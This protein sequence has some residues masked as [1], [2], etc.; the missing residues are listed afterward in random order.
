MQTARV[1]FTDWHALGEQPFAPL[2]GSRQAAGASIA[3]CQ[4]LIAE[5]Y[6]AGSPVQ[7]RAAP[8]ALAAASSKRRFQAATGM[9]PLEYVH[10]LRIEEAKQ[11]LEAEAAPVEAVANDVGYEDA[12]FFSRLFRRNVGLSPNEYRKRFG[13]MRRALQGG[14]N[15]DASSPPCPPSRSTGRQ[16]LSA[17]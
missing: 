16:G 2:A 14:V 15:L 11:M 4:P 3:R 12:G 6:R 5:Q 1:N 9:P 10:I 8:S 13:S 7:A 17:S